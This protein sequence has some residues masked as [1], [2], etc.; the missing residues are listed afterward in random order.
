MSL[1]DII[2]III[3]SILPMAFLLCACQLIIIGLIGLI[4]YYRDTER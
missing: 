4:K 3:A 2:M 1:F